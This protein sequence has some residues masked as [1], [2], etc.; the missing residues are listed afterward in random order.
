MGIEG[1]AVRRWR[2]RVRCLAIGARPPTLNRRRSSRATWADG[3]GRSVWPD[4][5]QS[6]LVFQN[7]ARWA[8]TAQCRSRSSCR[9]NR[10]GRGRR[11]R[12]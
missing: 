9:G 3:N 8:A 2:I 10:H 12:A 11:W 6:D 4:A 7:S 5:E 1:P